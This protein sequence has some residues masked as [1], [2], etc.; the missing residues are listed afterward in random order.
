MFAGRLARRPA[1]VADREY[2]QR[3][4]VRQDEAL[5]PG[6]GRLQGQVRIGEGVHA[7]APE[8]EKRHCP[9]QLRLLQ[10]HE[11]R[12]KDQQPVHRFRR[13]TGEPKR[14]GELAGEKKDLLALILVRSRAAE[15]D[16]HAGRRPEPP[17]LGTVSVAIIGEGSKGV[18]VRGHNH[19][20]CG[21]K[22]TALHE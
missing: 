2:R 17:H 7:R 12:V 1:V 5:C 10:P 11:R 20:S 18:P 13:K 4:F 9:G 8:I 15:H 3:F 22:H 6:H 14:R 16:E 21:R 19:G